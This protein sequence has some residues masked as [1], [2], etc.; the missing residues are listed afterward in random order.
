M[1]G[2]INGAKASAFHEIFTYGEE[3]DV[4]RLRGHSVAESNA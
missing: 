2:A 1:K 4:F 3:Q